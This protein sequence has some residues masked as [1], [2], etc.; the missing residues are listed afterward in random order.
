[1]S[2]VLNGTD[3]LSDVDGSA[4]T[5]AI[6]GTDANTGIFFPAADTIAFAEGGTEVMR[7]DSSGKLLV[8]TTTSPG[9]PNAKIVV[10]GTA[11][12]GVQLAS[13]SNGGAL[14]LGAGGGGLGF[15][16][17]TGAVG[18][19]SYT[20]RARIDSSGNLLV[21]TTSA[22]TGIGGR[23]IVGGGRPMAYSIDSGTLQIKGDSGGWNMGTVF[24]GSSGTNRGG[25]GVAGVGDTLSYYFVGQS[26]SGTGVQLANGGT[27][28]A[29]LSDEREKNIHGEIENALEKV[30]QI[31]GLYFNYKTDEPGTRR[32]VG[33]SA[34]K[35]QSVLPEA[36]TELERDFD[37]P[38]EDTKRLTLS[39]TDVV[40]LLVQALKEQQAIITEQEV[41]MGQ[42][43]D[44]L[45]NTESTM[46]L[47]T[48]MFTESQQ[49]ITA[50]TAR[51][52]ALE[53]TQP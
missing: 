17:Y 42:L 15:Y 24:F 3:G 44:Q 53:G 49:T 48:E 8:G 40:P 46:S 52:A 13:T 41:K 51:V 28:W 33:F 11:D 18:S 47:L 14:L 34:Q 16:T 32:R 19:E 23:F 38:T 4:A 37:N 5:P 10:A 21:G 9:S 31:S 35:V 1:M 20:E 7:I 43:V 30:A 6:R 25:F 36:V 12:P 22:P 50:L 2:L 26:G 39:T 27:S 29:A 45:T